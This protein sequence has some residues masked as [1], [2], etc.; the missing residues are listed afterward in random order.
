M[1]QNLFQN[2]NKIS[3]FKLSL[4]SAMLNNDPTLYIFLDLCYKNTQSLPI[5][6]TGT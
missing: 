4:S 1:R 3:N 6:H 2:D 5:M